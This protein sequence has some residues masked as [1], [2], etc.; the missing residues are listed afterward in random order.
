MRGVRGG[1][2]KYFCF[3]YYCLLVTKFRIRSSVIGMLAVF[4]KLSFNNIGTYCT[5]YQ[6]SASYNCPLI[7]FF[8]GI[9]SFILI[10]RIWIIINIP[11]YNLISL[12]HECERVAHCVT[13][14]W[15]NFSHWTSRE[16]SLRHSSG[17][18]TE[19]FPLS[20]VICAPVD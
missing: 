18:G 15:R 19:A 11:E 1:F 16:T 12:G 8:C 9:H 13:A 7:I 6:L 10:F 4:V 2:I 20:S 14:R 5:L 3:S 17:W